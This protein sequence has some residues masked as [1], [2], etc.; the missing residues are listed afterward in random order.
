MHGHGFL[1]HSQTNKVFLPFRQLYLFLI[2][3]FFLTFQKTILVSITTRD[4]SLSI[5]SWCPT[6]ELILEIYLQGVRRFRAVVAGR[7]GVYQLST[8]SEMMN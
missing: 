6:R 1:V 8:L 4:S 2:E 7:L 5:A 3:E